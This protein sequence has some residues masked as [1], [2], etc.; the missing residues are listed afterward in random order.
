[1]EEDPRRV[2]EN[3]VAPPARFTRRS[4]IRS[5]IIL[6][7]LAYVVVREPGTGFGFIA[8][9]IVVALSVFAVT[10]LVGRRR[11]HES[12]AYWS[13]QIAFSEDGF[14]NSELFPGIV[15][16]PRPVLGR[17]G[18]SGGRLYIRE[19]GVYWIAGSWATPRSEI[20]GKF[21]L[22]WSDV[23]TADVSRIPFKVNFLGGGL[24]LEMANGQGELYGEFL[25]SR[26]TMMSALRRTPLG[27]AS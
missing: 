2:T 6:A 12:G 27:R 25:G 8:F 18:L 21:H 10:F 26:R 4:A 15:R 13:G 23:E 3:A 16:T 5:V 19:D 9:L 20:S 22:A 24:T 7:V 11:A 14:G 17:Q 1:M